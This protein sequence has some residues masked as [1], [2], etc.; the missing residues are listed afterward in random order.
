MPRAWARHDLFWIRVAQW[1]TFLSARPDIP[2]YPVLSEWAQLNRPVIVR[3]TA[4]GEIVDGV[5]FGLPLPPAQGKS[6]IAGLLPVACISRRGSPPLLADAARSSPKAW[7]H[8]IDRIVELSPD[9]RSYGSLAWQDMTGLPYLS[10]TSDLDVI[11]RHDDAC[12]TELRLAQ[13]EKI[14][15]AAPMKIDG[16]II[17]SAGIAV[18]WRELL[19]GSP[20]VIGKRIDGAGIMTRAEFLTGS[21]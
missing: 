15:R 17:N 12:T 19:L 14:A 11:W 8:T 3:R 10:S 7:R 16:E 2:R 5:P 6:R 21:G 1:D 20:T 9:A 18:P 4:P 13:I